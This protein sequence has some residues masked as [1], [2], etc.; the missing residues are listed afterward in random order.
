MS[1]S[2]STW[3]WTVIR[4]LG[5]DAIHHLPCSPQG[6][7]LVDHS[8]FGKSYYVVQ[9]NFDRGCSAQPPP[10]VL[11]KARAYTQ[12]QLGPNLY[13]VTSLLGCG[14]P[15]LFDNMAP[16]ATSSAIVS[17]YGASSPKTNPSSPNPGTP[18]TPSFQKTQL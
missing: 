17:A 16:A 5:D 11:E 14:L 2:N 4:T 12:V 6:V 1:A 10:E 9:H 3:T 18:A 7:P 13:A 8:I 15:Q